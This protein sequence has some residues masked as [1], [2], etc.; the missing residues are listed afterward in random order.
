MHF[1]LYYY[2]AGASAAT[3][4][5]A[6]NCTHHCIKKSRDWFCLLKKYCAGFLPCKFPLQGPAKQLLQFAIRG[7]KNKKKRVYPPPIKIDK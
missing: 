1:P 5:V 7:P 3:G 4:I 2:S 6:L